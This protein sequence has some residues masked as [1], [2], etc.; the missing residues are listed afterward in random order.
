MNCK[1]C[2]D[3]CVSQSSW[4]SLTA[5]VVKHFWNV[6]E[7]SDRQTKKFFLL[8]VWRQA[9][10]VP[11]FRNKEGYSSW[12]GENYFSNNTILPRFPSFTSQILFIPSSP[13][14]PPTRLLP[15]LYKF[16]TD[17]SPRWVFKTLKNSDSTR[18]LGNFLGTQFFQMPNLKFPFCLFITHLWLVCSYSLVSF[19]PV[20]VLSNADVNNTKRLKQKH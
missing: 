20:S 11:Y 12:K 5:R 19:S 16:V 10:P 14:S 7:T 2:T 6:K 1:A 17:S 3:Q 4:D 18:S 8:S 13:P 15:T 9:V